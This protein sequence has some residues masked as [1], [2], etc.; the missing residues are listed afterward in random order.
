MSAPCLVR[1]SVEAGS[2]VSTGQHLVW[3]SPDPSVLDLFA[4]RVFQACRSSFCGTGFLSNATLSKQLSD[5]PT[6]G[7]VPMMRHHACHLCPASTPIPEDCCVTTAPM[8]PH[9][10]LCHPPLLSGVGVLLS[11]RFCVHPCQRSRDNNRS[12]RTRCLPLNVSVTTC[13]T[14]AVHV[15]NAGNSFHVFVSLNNVV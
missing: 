13:S 4:L 8:Q 1:F 7:S 14:R 10:A 12:A 9:R 2:C 3:K 11:T 6:R 15:C 5:V